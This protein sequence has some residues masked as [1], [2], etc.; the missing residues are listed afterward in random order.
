MMDK[1]EEFEALREQLRREQGAY[2]NEN[3]TVGDFTYGI[4]KIRSCGE[5]AKL[6]IGKFCSIAENVTIMLGG[7][8]RPEW[9]TTYPFN[10]LLDNFS[11]IKG[12]PA[13]KGD[14]AIGNDVWIASGAKIMSGVT[15]GDGAVIGANALVT[16]DVAP[17]DI[18]GGVPAKCI[19]KR[20]SEEIVK[21]MLEMRW[22]NWPDQKIIAAVPY[23]Q[24]N[25]ISG[26]IQ[27]ANDPVWQ[28]EE[29]KENRKENHA[30]EMEQKEL[31]WHEKYDRKTV[32]LRQEINRLLQEKTADS[33]QKVVG[34]FGNREFF[35][36][37]KEITDFAFMYLMAYIY[38]LEMQS[39]VEETILDQGDT[40]EELNRYFF[41]WRTLLYRLDF[42]IEE[43]VEEQFLSFLT[44][45]K[46][47]AEMI[48]VSLKYQ[49]MRPAQLMAKMEK[50][51]EKNG[52]DDYLESIR[53]VAR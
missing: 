51:F 29:Q 5:G 32:L 41:Q 11:D 19:K 44:E 46:V 10:V 28:K 27:I 26:L 39:G 15:I 4:P 18:V 14:V 35:E 23:L 42:E 1:L 52:M 47:S 16:K 30:L 12:H 50:I 43:D 7:E 3:I 53:K 22:W 13:T 38:H 49:V 8:H 20:F 34:I 40:M 9:N 33:R 24:S 17:Y 25:D 37:Y 21:V 2:V 6:S 48:V 31:E 36:P 45:H